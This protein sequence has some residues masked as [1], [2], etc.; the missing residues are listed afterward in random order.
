MSTILWYVGLSQSSISHANGNQHSQV[1]KQV[2]ILF[3]KKWK[4]VSQSSGCLCFLS[5]STIITVTT[6]PIMCNCDWWEGIWGRS[7]LLQKKSQNSPFWTKVWTPS[8]HQKFLDPPLYWRGIRWDG[9]ICR[10]NYLWINMQQHETVLD[11]EPVRNGSRAQITHCHG[12]YV[13][14][15]VKG[16]KVIF[17]LPIPFPTQPPE[18][19]GELASR[20]I[21]YVYKQCSI[22]IEMI[23]FTHSCTC[24][25]ARNFQWYYYG[26]FL[27]LQTKKIQ[28]I[29]F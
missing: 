8:P 19:P 15:G 27:L 9:C 4:L 26:I 14:D 29:F 17:M 23:F 11:F 16:M 7:N 10:L 5:W 1:E 2:F 18:G 24:Q 20:Q 6:R 21:M 3:F 22:V 13:W 12:K 28:G 25:F